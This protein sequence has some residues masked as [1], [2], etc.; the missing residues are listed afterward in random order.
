MATSSAL[1]AGAREV[2]WAP[3]VAPQR[4]RRLYATDA[5][6][7]VD[8]EQIDEVG[9][10]L[11]A[12]CQSILR[13]TA[14]H[15]GRVACPRCEAA[16]LRPGSVW[17]RGQVLRCEAC[18]WT[19]TWGAYYDT[20]KGKH[21]KGGSAL[22]AFREFVERY[23]LAPT[24]RARMLAIDR[25]LHTFHHQLKASTRPAGINLIDGTLSEVLDFLQQLTDGPHEVGSRD[26][27]ATEHARRRDAI[28]RAQLGHRLR[29]LR[30]AARL[31]GPKL[32]ART[33]MSAGK[34]SNIETGRKPPSVGDLERLAAAL[35]LAPG[36]AAELIRSARDLAPDGPT[37][38]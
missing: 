15:K 17:R 29:T 30:L 19:A 5:L 23:P 16:V 25:L 13:A 38:R 31:S 18:G 6:G 26:A 24:P 28:A 32:A 21:L 27:S 10:A 11:Y 22:G 1:A 34:L 2:R 20:Y 37:R 14:A 12:R 35:G 3:R 33:G 8:D 36:E 9:L 7:I 4:I